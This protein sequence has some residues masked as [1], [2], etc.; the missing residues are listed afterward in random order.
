MKIGY[1]LIDSF[2]KGYK[3]DK[4]NGIQA[5]TAEHFA[6]SA[7]K[8]LQGQG[9]EIDN[10]AFDALDNIIKERPYIKSN[11]LM[12]DKD[13]AE[14]ADFNYITSNV[15]YSLIKYTID[16]NGLP[17]MFISSSLNEIFNLMDNYSCECLICYD[18]I[19][20]AKSTDTILGQILRNYGVCDGIPSFKVMR[21]RQRIKEQ[22]HTEVS[23]VD[24]STAYD[25]Y[26]QQQAQAQQKAQNRQSINIQSANTA[27]NNQ[28]EEVPLETLQN[29]IIEMEKQHMI[30][31]IDGSTFETDPVIG[32]TKEINLIAEKMLKK[33][34]ANVVLLGEA[35]VGKTEIVN[36]LAY[37]LYNGLIDGENKNKYAI[38]GMS[39]MDL[40]S[41]TKFRGEL[42]AKLQCIVNTLTE[43]SKHQPVILFIDEIHLIVGTGAGGDNGADIS[44]L[45]K[46]MLS[47]GKVRVI[48]ST[49]YEEYNNISQDKALNRRF[50]TISVDEPTQEET[51]QILSGIKP[52]YE[53]YFN[54]RISDTSIQQIVSLCGTYIKDKFFPDKAIEAMDSI[55]AY[56]K[57]NRKSIVGNE[58]IVHTISEISK[59]D[60]SRVQTSNNKVTDLKDLLK[61]Q[62][63]GQDT[64]IEKMVN[65]VRTYKAGFNDENKPIA[66]VLFMGTTGTGKTELSKQLAEKLGIKFIR[67]DMSEYSEEYTVSKLIGSPAGYVGHDEGGLLTEAISK[68]P[69]CV[70]LLDEIE[71]AHSKIFNTLLQVMDYGT[72]TDAR[73]KRV[74]FTNVIIIMT[75]NVGVTEK[76]TGSIGFSSSKSDEKEAI[77][78][79]T[80]SNVFPMEFIGRLDEV[81]QFNNITKEIAIKVIDKEMGKIQA[82][83]N[84]KGYTVSITNDVMEYLIDESNI[85]KLGA[86]NIGK[87]ITKHIT[88]VVVDYVLSNQT[89]KNIIIS[90][91][92][93]GKIIADTGKTTLIKEAVTA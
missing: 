80:L 88:P 14:I 23:E 86:R 36:G 85:D 16:N 67:F 34:R 73:G 31:S 92:D 33:K 65:I 52:E 69:H 83:A 7:L 78:I 17:V 46:P 4:D 72:L 18:Y 29:V 48:G 38:Y 32:R 39:V 49:T 59:I 40:M 51:I 15:L 28:S 30:F 44:N 26:V 81:V 37:R 41:G 8:Q 11:G 25:Q 56:C 64:A 6:V 54:I 12:A 13:T 47:E 91:T 74:D 43:L 3:S 19:K 20:I 55:M 57:F 58:D 35:G 93:T 76:A 84:K 24:K 77:A 82:K 90:L 2:F 10:K 75:S 60:I 63:F 70:L 61:Q 87:L 5:F 89:N 68:T 27:Q 62:V 1:D 42:E 22:S 50:S 53:R 21:L 79:K 45:L 71:K 9:I 66:N